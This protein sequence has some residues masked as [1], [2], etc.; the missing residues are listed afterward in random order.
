MNSWSTQ[1]DLLFFD[2]FLIIFI[3]VFP[4]NVMTM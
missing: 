2:D 4:E 1:I 3:P